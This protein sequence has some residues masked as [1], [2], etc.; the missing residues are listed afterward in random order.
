MKKNGL[1]IVH[2]KDL[3]GNKWSK[4]LHP[5]MLNKT[6]YQITQKIRTIGQ[7]KYGSEYS[8]VLY[9]R[10]YIKGW[11]S[12]KVIKPLSD[13]GLEGIVEILKKAYDDTYPDKSINE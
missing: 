6:G 9:D 2:W 8:T 5:A 1:A 11:I 10:E 7:S 13:E 3:Q 4:S 12:S